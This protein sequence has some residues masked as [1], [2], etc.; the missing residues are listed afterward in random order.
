[1]IRVKFADRSML[2]KAFSSKDR[3]KAVYAFVR[4][5]IREDTRA[6]KFVLCMYLLNF[7]NAFFTFNADAH[8]FLHHH[9]ETLK[10]LTPR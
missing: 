3:I 4:L 8:K 2:E 10:F 1:M 5:S 7:S 6:H 9:A